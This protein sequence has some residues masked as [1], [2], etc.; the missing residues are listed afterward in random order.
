MVA[1]HVVE[2]EGA[3]PQKRADPLLF[4]CVRLSGWEKIP[5]IHKKIAFFRN[6]RIKEGANACF[7]VVDEFYMC[8]RHN[9][10]S[11]LHIQISSPVKGL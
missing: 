7:T 3:V 8:I 9:A 5:K 1:E 6:A 11:H 4:G 2:G 10:E